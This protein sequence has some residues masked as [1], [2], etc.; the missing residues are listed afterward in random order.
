M[1]TAC[2]LCDRLRARG[3][4][5]TP[6]RRTI[7]EV[8]EKARHPPSAEQVCEEVRRRLPDVSLATV[9]KTLKELVQMGEIQELNYQGDRCRF[10]PKT[11]PHGHIQCTGC[12]QLHDVDL[13]FD[14]L[15]LPK[16]LRG[17]YE[18]DRHEVVFYGRCPQCQARGK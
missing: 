12:G 17:G 3:Y 18:I 10:D 15:E 8:L 13:G 5:V 11:Q 4:S 6:Q 9:Y 14:D 7:F 2:A 16:R 1:E